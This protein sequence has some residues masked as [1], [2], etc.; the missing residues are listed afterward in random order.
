MNVEDHRDQIEYHARRAAA[1]GRASDLDDHR[2]DGW[3]GLLIASQRYDDKGGANLRTFADSRIRG[4]IIDG[5]RRR[6]PFGSTAARRHHDIPTIRSTA[7]EVPLG[8]PKE[9]PRCNGLIEYDQH[10]CS[11]CKACGAFVIATATHIV[12]LPD[13]LAMTKPLAA[14]RE[15]DGG[16]TVLRFGGAKG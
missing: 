6:H 9:C 5:I 15:E 13:T 8:F 2:Q 4:Q 1:A 10:K 3:L 11:R 12:H 7:L 14:L 16:A